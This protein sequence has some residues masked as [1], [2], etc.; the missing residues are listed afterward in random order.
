M[1]KTKVILLLLLVVCAH[2]SAR[3]EFH[4][5]DLGQYVRASGVEFIG[6][7]WC[8]PYGDQVF[9]GIPY[10]IDGIIQLDAK[11]PREFGQFHRDRVDFIDVGR[12]FEELRLL[13]GAAWKPNP[14][15]AIAVIELHYTDGTIGELPVR[16]DHHVRDHWGEN[17]IIEIPNTDPNTRIAWRAEHRD[18]AR[19]DKHLR[20]FESVHRNPHPAK[21]V[22]TLSL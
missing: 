14:G 12:R 3:A 4:A 13:S 18:P 21:E 22:A 10:K 5:V 16:F 7:K 6:A 8:I 17:H 20:F 2:R 15:E 19:W 11:G 1:M 9:E